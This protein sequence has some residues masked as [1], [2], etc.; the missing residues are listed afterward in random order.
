V[1]GLG[2]RSYVGY[3]LHVGAGN[4]GALAVVGYTSLV[5]CI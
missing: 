4:F 3:R 1:V 2:R 5:L